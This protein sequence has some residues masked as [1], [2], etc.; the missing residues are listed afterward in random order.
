MKMGIA[1]L[2][3]L[4]LA[5]GA[6]PAFAQYYDNGPINGTNDAW[7]INSGYVVSDTFFSTY[8]SNPFVF[9]FEFGAWEFPGDM[10]SAVQWSITSTQNARGVYGSGT[11]K[12]SDRFISTDQFGYDIDL[13]GVSGLY[14]PVNSD[15]I[16][17]LSLQNASVTN[18]DP[19]YWDENS[20]VGCGSPGCPSKALQSTVGTIPS[21]AFTVHLCSGCTCGL[22]P[23][24]GC[25]L[26]SGGTPEP[27][28]I[29]LFGSGILALVSVLRGKLNL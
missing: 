20:G 1:L 3:I 24:E 5:L 14:V 17:W 4:C 29:L 27:S 18:G 8:F 15:T 10:I 12:T 6:V 7:T 9:G 13:I 21:E 2:T 23:A 22:S 25:S 28:S 26:E 11:A 16:Y 19:A